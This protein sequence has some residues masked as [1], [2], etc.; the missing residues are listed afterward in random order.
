[1]VIF[2]RCPCGSL[3]DVDECPGC[4]SCDYDRR[5]M[6]GLGVRNGDG[7]VTLVMSALVMIPIGVEPVRMVLGDVVVADEVTQW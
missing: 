6:A 7:T 2:M 1:M 5:S 4:G 3:T